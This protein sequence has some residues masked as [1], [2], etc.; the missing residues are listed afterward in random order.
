MIICFKVVSRICLSSLEL[1]GDFSLPHVDFSAGL[2]NCPAVE[3]GVSGTLG[4]TSQWLVLVI[5]H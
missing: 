3:N 2:S 5:F 1:S 4:L